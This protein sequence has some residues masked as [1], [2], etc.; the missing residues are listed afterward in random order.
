MFCE[1]CGSKLADDARFCT[2]CGAKV[3]KSGAPGVEDLGTAHVQAAV[4][5]AALT[6]APADSKPA[7]RVAFGRAVEATKQQS[8]RK[9]PLIVLVALVAALLTGTAWAA[10]TVYNEFIAP[11]F[12]LPRIEWIHDSSTQ[13]PAQPDSEQPSEP[14]EPADDPQAGIPVAQGNPQSILEVAEIVAMEPERIPEFL[15]SQGLADSGDAIPGYE[16][17]WTATGESPYT[18]VDPDGQLLD[19]RTP[20]YNQAYAQILVGTDISPILH[21]ILMPQLIG[22]GMQASTA[23]SIRLSGVPFKFNGAA[24]TDPMAADPAKASR[25]DIEAF[26]RLCKLGPVLGDFTYTSTHNGPDGETLDFTVR[27]CTGYVEVNGQLSL[28]YLL[29]IQGGFQCELGVAPMDTA[30]TVIARNVQLYDETQW[31]AASDEE[32]AQMAAASIVQ[33]MVSG[34][35]GL[36]VNVLTGEKQQLDFENGNVE[37]PIWVPSDGSM[38]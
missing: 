3:G 28:W 32:R 25:T 23:D 34:N 8:R 17:T 5:N 29:M 37:A 19:N 9:V 26:A 31:S 24:T 14:E 4:S 11:T 21:G 33:D 18:A 15:R 22:D 7:G 36:R 13:E 35:G 27:A 38:E 6:P 20:A 10:V 2:E 12:D 30:E 1:Q 16:H